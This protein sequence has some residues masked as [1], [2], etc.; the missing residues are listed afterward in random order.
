MPDG[1]FGTELLQRGGPFWKEASRNV[2]DWFLRNI[3]NQMIKASY[4]K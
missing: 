2:T 3:L 4:H 1:G